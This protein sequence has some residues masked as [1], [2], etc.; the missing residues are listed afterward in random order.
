MQKCVAQIYMAQ[1]C[2][3]Q[4]FVKQIKESLE[5]E[6]GYRGKRCMYFSHKRKFETLLHHP[7]LLLFE[8]H[9]DSIGIH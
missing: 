1:S 2:G 5:T 8:L 3:A 6:F 7:V 9:V 4:R